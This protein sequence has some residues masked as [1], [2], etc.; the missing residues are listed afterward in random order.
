MYLDPNHPISR[1]EAAF[2]DRWR[3]GLAAAVPEFDEL[4]L[5]PLLEAGVALLRKT[6]T[7]D[8]QIASRTGG[9]SVSIHLDM[10]GASQEGDLPD[11]AVRSY[12]TLRIWQHFDE[13]AE[14][15][16]PGEVPVI[17]TPTRQ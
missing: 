9:T 16:T 4:V 17:V 2:L 12:V 5:Q 7:A 6:P 11:E 1:S 3:T 8:L 13:I 10:Q 15:L 14:I